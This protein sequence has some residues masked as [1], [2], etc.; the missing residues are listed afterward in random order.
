MFFYSITFKSTDFNMQ[1]DK[2]SCNKN[3]DLK[4]D[5]CTQI[6]T[7]ISKTVCTKHIK[8]TE[9]NPHFFPP[10]S[11]YTYCMCNYEIGF[12]EL[13]HLSRLNQQKSLALGE[14]L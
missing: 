8:E 6:D 4:L 1:S 7:E 2:C 13:Q 5:T 12:N 11:K 9:N 10:L 14:F 3:G